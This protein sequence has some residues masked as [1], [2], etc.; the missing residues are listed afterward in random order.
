MNRTAF[1]LIELLVGIAIIA[2]LAAI[3]FPVFARARENARRTSCLSNIKQIALG[4]MQYA[5]DYDGRLVPSIGTSTP[6]Y[7]FNGY[8]FHWFNGLDPYLKS[9]QVFFCP[10]DSDHDSTKQFTY[11]NI[12]Y[13]WNHYG[14]CYYFGTTGPISPVYSQGG[15]PLAAIDDPSETVLLG[16]SHGSNP[17]GV[18]YSGTYYGIGARHL[19]GANFG[20]VDGHVKWFK[21]PGVITANNALW[22]TKG[23]AGGGW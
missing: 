4:S 16:D 12:S 9:T 18:H 15:M 2:I 8:L 5:Q 19:E 6:P 23:V 20:F 17:W 1:T 11:A 3:L 13:G 14:L 22:N 10:S 7:I 21:I